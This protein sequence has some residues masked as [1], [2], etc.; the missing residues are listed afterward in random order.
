MEMLSVRF[1]RDGPEKRAVDAFVARA[2]WKAFGTRPQPARTYAAA[3]RGGRP[4]GC[5]GHVQAGP[6]GWFPVERVYRLDR[7]ELPL[8]ITAGNTVEFGRFVALQPGL[9]P[10][11]VYAGIRFALGAGKEYGI[12][13]YTDAVHAIVERLGLTLCSLPDA[14][15]CLDAVASGDLPYYRTHVSRPYLLDLE[16]SCRKIWERL[17]ELYRGLVPPP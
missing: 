2:Y 12:L 11:L 10:V 7:A 14:T 3:M 4:V 8:P 5:L 16:D 9:T 1:I 15:A 13:E 17:P 6:S